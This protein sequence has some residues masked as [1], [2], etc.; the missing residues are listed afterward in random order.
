MSPNTDHCH[1]VAAGLCPPWCTWC[2][3][4]APHVVFNVVHTVGLVQCVVLIVAVWQAA[5]GAVE[6][7]IAA[8]AVVTPAAAEGV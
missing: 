4:P 2:K 6:A 7:V 1:D 8:E 3:F 5:P